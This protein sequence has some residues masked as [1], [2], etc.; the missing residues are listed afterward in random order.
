MSLKLEPVD[1]NNV[2]N[3]MDVMDAHDH[4]DFHHNK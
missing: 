1:A 4:V 2:N 3:A